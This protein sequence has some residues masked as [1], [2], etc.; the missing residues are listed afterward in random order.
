MSRGGT[1]AGVFSTHFWNQKTMFFRIVCWA[2]IARLARIA[3]IS[4]AHWG[5]PIEKTHKL[6]WESIWLIQCVYSTPGLVCGC[7]GFVMV[8]SWDLLGSFW[9]CVDLVLGLFWAC[10][11]LVLGLFLACSGV[12]F[13]LLWI[14]TGVVLGFF[15]AC[16]GE[17]LGFVWGCSGLV[18]S[19]F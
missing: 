19:S 9:G 16:S 11:G 14:S 18:L 2:L 15:W 8:L 12:V 6:V 3:P 5:K 17:V 4:I 13:G 7:S 10:F 1:L